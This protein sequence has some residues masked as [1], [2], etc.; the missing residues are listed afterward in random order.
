MDV[1]IFHKI[2]ISCPSWATDMQCCPRETSEVSRGKQNISFRW[3]CYLP[4]SYL[5]ITVVLPRLLLF[6]PAKNRRF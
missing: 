3:L 2:F 6:L 5:V 1:P 4:A